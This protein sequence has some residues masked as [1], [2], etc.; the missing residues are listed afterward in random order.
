MAIHELYW[1]PPTAICCWGWAWLRHNWA[2]GKPIRL[3]GAIGIVGLMTA[4][5]ACVS[6]FA[7][8]L[9]SWINGRFDWLT[10]FDGWG[11]LL[12]I[13]GIVIGV[14]ATGR[15]RLFTTSSALLSLA[16]WVGFVA[17]RRV[18]LLS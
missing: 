5:A 14:M 4:T 11:I 1:I 8:V 16:A 6:L 10:P 12:S 2:A 13:S 15:L 17:A 3:R 7:A 9:Y 18:P